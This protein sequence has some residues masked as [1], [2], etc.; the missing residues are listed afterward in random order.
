MSPFIVA[1][2]SCNHLGSLDRALAIVDAAAKAG[3]NGFKMQC[4]TAGTMCL[5]RS[6]TLDSGPWK[7]RRLA[8]LYEEAY[9]PWEWFPVIFERCKSLGMVPFAA[10]FDTRAVDY[11]EELG[12]DR[13]KVASFELTD[14]PL[15]RYMASKGKPMILSTGMASDEE[16]FN[17]LTCTFDAPHV[18]LLR[19]VSAYPSDP[20]DANLKEFADL[21]DPWGMSDHSLGVGVAVAAATLGAVYI[22]K[23]LTLKRSDGGPDA[24]FSMEPDE[25]RAMAIACRQAS[26]AIGVPSYGCGPKESTSLRRSLWVCKD[27]KPGDWLELG[28]NVVTAR[29]ALGLSPDTDLKL[30]VASRPIAANSPLTREDIE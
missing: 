19:C 28:V 27:V 17:A 26:A 9:T 3:A 25:F 29:P 22:E 4:W 1:E 2:L 8:E 18:T 14:L 24:G 6:Y 12:V 11:L 30:A 23:H 15:I 7:G 20:A 5:D 10:A 21:Y 13:H 16:I